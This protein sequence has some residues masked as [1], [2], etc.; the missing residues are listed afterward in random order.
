LRIYRIV[1]GETYAKIK[2]SG[3]RYWLVTIMADRYTNTDFNNSVSRAWMHVRR[4]DGSTSLI[5]AES[6][7]EIAARRKHMLEEHEA[8]QP[9]KCAICGAKFDPQEQLQDHLKKCTAKK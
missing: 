6:V 3:R 4:R 2:K 8:K 9:Y 1:Q 5:D 7:A